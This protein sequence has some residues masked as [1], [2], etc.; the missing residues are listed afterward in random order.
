MA[1]GEVVSLENAICVGNVFIY[2]GKNTSHEMYL[3]NDVF[4]VQ[5]GTIV[6]RYNVVHRS[7]EL[8]YLA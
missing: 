2:F 5:C 3:F 7:P 8:L 6:S 4:S 1:A